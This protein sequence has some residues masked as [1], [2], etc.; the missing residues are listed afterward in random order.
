MK[1][2]YGTIKSEYETVYMEREIL[3]SGELNDILEGANPSSMNGL[4]GESTADYFSPQL[5]PELTYFITGRV[6]ACLGLGGIKGII[7]NNI[8]VLGAIV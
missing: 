4:S 5:I 3:P 1:I 2:S 8:Y 7:R 6:S